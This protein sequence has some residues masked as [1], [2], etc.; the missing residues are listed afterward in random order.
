[1]K[2]C[3][4]PFP[5][6]DR[7]ISQQSVP[8]KRAKRSVPTKRPKPSVVSPPSLPAKTPKTSASKSSKPPV[9]PKKEA[10]S[11]ESLHL[12][13]DR[14]LRQL[15]VASPHL[16]NRRKAR[17]RLLSS[18]PST[19]LRRT[20][21]TTS[22]SSSIRW[23]SARSARS[24]SRIPFPR[25]SPSSSSS[26]WSSTTPFSTTS[27]PILC[28]F[29]GSL[30]FSTAM[31][32]RLEHLF[33]QGLAASPQA[34]A[35]LKSSRGKTRQRSGARRATFAA[36]Q[37]ALRKLA[38]G[39]GESMKTTNGGESVTTAKEEE[40]MITTKGEESVTT[41]KEDASTTNGRNVTT[42]TLTATRWEERR[43]RMAQ[44]TQEEKQMGVRE[45]SGSEPASAEEVAALARELRGLETETLQQVAARAG[46]EA[47]RLDLRLL[48]PKK[49]RLL[50][51]ELQ[52]VKEEESLASRDGG[53]G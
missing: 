51:E 19:R 10:S 9:K 40:S 22:P 36:I 34:S 35:L 47:G 21:R 53:E 3:Q 30:P 6:T 14:L 31:A 26:V 20:F 1:M 13:C 23:T 7:Y 46:I 41:T 33:D 48:E 43:R 8:K 32:L 50:M 45:P 27:P 2:E 17:T 37:A 39:E 29:T 18:L 24:S 5:L 4:F 25:W 44:L 49:Q 15:E 42:D 11:P 12:F 16:L 38:S 28:R 52:R